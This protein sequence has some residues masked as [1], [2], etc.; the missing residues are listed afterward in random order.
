MHIPTDP[1][2]RKAPDSIRRELEEVLSKIWENQYFLDRKDLE[3][4]EYF[5]KKGLNLEV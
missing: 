3:K 5:S 4:L 2:L 1:E